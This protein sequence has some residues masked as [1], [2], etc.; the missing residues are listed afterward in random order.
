MNELREQGHI[1]VLP[2]VGEKNTLL[3]FHQHTKGLPLVRNKMG[4]LEPSMNAPA[5]DPDV[6]L[7]PLLAFDR[8]H[9]RLGYGAGFYDRTL[10]ALRSKKSITAI[11]IAYAYQEVENV[12]M[13][14]LDAQLDKIVTSVNV[15]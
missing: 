11:G 6:L 12:P 7:V 1:I 15:F 9:N 10:T 14:D 2:I 3:S 8:R 4:I 5:L 13:G